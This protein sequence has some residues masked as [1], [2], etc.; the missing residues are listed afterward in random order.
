MDT[1]HSDLQSLADRVERLEEQY[2]SLRSEV[3]TE[4][5]ALR[6]TDGKTRA[7]LC[8]LE[9]E[10]RLDLYDKDL[11]PCA[12]LKVSVEGPALWLT[13]AKTK[14]SISLTLNESKSMISLKGASGSVLVTASETGA[15][16]YIDANGTPSIRVTTGEDGPAIDLLDANGE[17]RLSLSVNRVMSD[18]GVA[19]YLTMHNSN[20][21]ASV[22]VTTLDDG[23][24][25]ALFDPTNPDANIGIRLLVSSGEP[26]R[27]NEFETSGHGI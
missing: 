22:V 26:A 20:G 5:L 24:S 12:S 27:V 21:M 15:A 16:I 2:R 9:E 1:S 14:Q 19:P 13:N 17:P 8:L 23:P 6:D 10:P 18:S 3:V 11:N 7:T 4:G 25:V